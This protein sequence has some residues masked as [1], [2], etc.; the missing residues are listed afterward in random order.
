MLSFSTFW[1]G[2]SLFLCQ[3]FWQAKPAAQ[4]TDVELAQMLGDSPWAQMVGPSAK[5]AA[6]SPVQIYLATAGP[7]ER[8]LA[9]R[10]R[11]IALRRPMD[12][13]SAP[14]R[15]EFA[16]WFAENQAGHIILAVRIGNSNAFSSESEIR[17]MQQD[18]L[19]DLGRSKAKSSSYFPPTSSDPNLYLAFPRGSMPPDKTVGF[20]LYLP[21]LPGPFRTVQFRVK[22]M[23]LDGKVEL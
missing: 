13:Q 3:T 7:M 8:A 2:A 11:R 20:S 15:E 1:L 10:N 21:G 17:R 22:D 4:W 6:G 18:C 14:L 9:E 16:A 5:S 19:M 12:P 23:L